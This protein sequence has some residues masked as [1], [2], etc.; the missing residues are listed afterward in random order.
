MIEIS[1]ITKR[2]YSLVALDN[3]SLT[4]PR[5]EVLGLLGPNG[6]GKTTMMK[7]VAGFLQ[8]DSG[9]VRPLNSAWP[10]I[11]YK[12]ERLLFPNQLRVSQY[13]EM[14]AG[15]SNISGQH[16]VKEVVGH[17][18]EQVDLLSAANKK[19][20]DCSKGMRQRL[21][22]AQ[23]L[24]GNPPLLLLDEPSN[25]L[26]PEGQTDILQVIQS[27]HASGKTIVISSHHLHEITQICTELVILNRGQIHYRNSMAEALAV[28]PHVSI[29]TDKDLAPMRTL[30]QALHPDVQIDGQRLI[31][32]NEAM[33]LR[34]AAMTILLQNGYDILH[35]EQKRITLAEIYAKAVQ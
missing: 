32:K 2:F 19:I 34:R 21:G 28:R 18:L 23:V 29:H 6:A 3:V 16:H 4:I 10:I 11:G 27:L 22:L 20:K 5:G 17:S 15:L 1:N 24:I 26:D 12:P 35:V 14:I 7:I 25:G 9:T 13:L 33:A 30:M 8:P 31:M